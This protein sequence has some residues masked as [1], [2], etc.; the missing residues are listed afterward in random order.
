M[1]ESSSCTVDRDR[2][3]AGVL[4]GVASQSHNFGPL[5]LLARML[6]KPQSVAW[7]TIQFFRTSATPPPP[8][9]PP[10]HF[11]LNSFTINDI[12][13]YFTSYLVLPFWSYVLPVNLKQRRL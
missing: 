7:P 13:L 6:K 12:V 10:S 11:L 2:V 5:N 8:L 4:V 1:Y 9:A 3:V